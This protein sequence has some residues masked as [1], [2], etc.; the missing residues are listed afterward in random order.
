MSNT[1]ATYLGG[2]A[3]YEKGEWIAPI[4]KL[5]TVNSDG[6]TGEEKIYNNVADAFAGIA[7]SI[8]NVHNDVTNVVSDSLVK[9]DE[10]T[11]IIKI[12]AEKKAQKSVLPTAKM[13]CVPFRALKKRKMTMRQ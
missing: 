8:T 10:D 3:K 9:Q 13:S 6:S 2:G 11:K 7:S 1:L 4:F 12:G 5:K